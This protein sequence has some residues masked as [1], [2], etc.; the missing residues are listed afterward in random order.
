MLMT[1]KTIAIFLSAAFIMIFLLGMAGSQEKNDTVGT[2]GA[3]IA[4]LLEQAGCPLTDEQKAAIE[5]LTPGP[6]LKTQ[7]F[8]ILTD[9]QKGILNTSP[10]PQQRNGGIIVSLN[11]RLAKAG[12]PLTDEQ[13]AAIEALTPG[14][15]LKA[16][17]FAIL[18]DTQKCILN[19]PPA[20]QQ[21]PGMTRAEMMNQ[22]EQA[23]CPLTKAQLDQLK[24]LKAGAGLLDR[25]KAILTPEQIAILGIL[26]GA[27]A[28]DQNLE[29]LAGVDE[30][31]VSI[32][33]LKQNY[34]NPFNP[35]TTIEYTLTNPGNVRVEIYGIIGQF[36]A[37]LV[38]SYQAAGMHTITWNAGDLA[39]GTYFVKIT[40]GLFTQTRKMTLIK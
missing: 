21:K 33:E 23:G 28:T 14:P 38:D 20:P 19:T 25:V 2:V 30:A 17:I 9:T 1:R 7:V 16:Q 12:C 4:A 22:L 3:R 32:G 37:T 35:S 29:K 26:F 8:A 24:A 31:P 40:S 11:E 34:P 6:D 27:A 10:T 39:G 15:D 18:D 13:K 5:A 36:V